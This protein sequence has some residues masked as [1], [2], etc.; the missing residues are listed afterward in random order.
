MEKR[1][2][3]LGFP[4]ESCAP[5]AIEPGCLRWVPRHPDPRSPKGLASVG[6]R[7]DPVQEVLAQLDQR[8][9]SLA[10]NHFQEENDC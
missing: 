2:Q 10:G 8:I 1:L 9:T 6:E 4:A 7:R 3:D 5:E